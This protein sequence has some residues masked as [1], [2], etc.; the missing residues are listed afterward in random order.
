MW[1]T[2]TAQK[3]MPL[4]VWTSLYEPAMLCWGNKSALKPQSLLTVHFSTIKS[5]IQEIGDSPHLST[6]CQ[7]CCS[8][9]ESESQKLPPA[10]KQLHLEG[11]RR[12]AHPDGQ[13]RHSASIKQHGDKE[14]DVNTRSTQQAGLSLP[15]TESYLQTLIPLHRGN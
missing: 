2:P 3:W 10:F 4:P 14:A 11:T 12:H 1:K 9:G 5:L 8:K 13:T 15:Q 6:W 7:S